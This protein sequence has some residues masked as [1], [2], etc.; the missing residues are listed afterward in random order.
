MTFIDEYKELFE[1]IK[2]C[3]IIPTYNN[4]KTLEIVI[5]NVLRFTKNIIVVNDGSTDNTNDI[6]K[7][8]ENFEIISYSKNK[9]K[10]FAL[11]TGFKKAIEFGYK[12]AI[13][14]DSDGQHNPD[15]LPIFLNEIVKN[16]NSFVVG[17]R[18]LKQENMPQK[19]GV[20]N[21]ISNFWFNFFTD[22]NLEDT[23]SGY[24]LYPLEVVD[25]LN[26]FTNKYEFELEVLVK[27]S[28]KGAKIIPVSINAYYPPKEERVTHFR[29]FKDFARISILNTF[30]SIWTIL[31]IKPYKILRSINKKK[32]Y[33]FFLDNFIK[34]SDS[35]AKIVFSVM[36]G[37]FMGIVPIWGYQLISAIA[38]AYIL[39]LNKPIVI[40]AANISI[41]PMMPIIIYLSY[42]TG[43]IFMGNSMQNV[44]SINNIS[45]EFIKNNFIQY[46]VGS[47]ILAML[48]S[49]LFGM[50]IF[51][52][53]KIFRKKS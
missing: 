39:K 21:R 15:E 45:F 11:K 38:L 8:F 25:K 19:S 33:N 16:P 24:R 40:V 26:L 12:Y 6:L 46:I 14:I 27:G 52:I 29:P 17:I 22:T 34:S 50:F 7:N 49:I 5:K 31:Y 51:I 9:G 30:F 41:A 36:L 28:W 4:N 42:V 3:V 1:N 37:V 18:N 47:T 35:N 53:L 48:S 23:Q 2:C 32:I 44:S 20:A 10:G 13:T 43:V